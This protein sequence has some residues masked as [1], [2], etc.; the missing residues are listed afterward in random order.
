MNNVNGIDISQH[1]GLAHL[2]CKNFKALVGRGFDY[3]DLFQAAC[4]GLIYAAESYNPELGKFSTYAVPMAKRS[5]QILVETQSRTVKIPRTAQVKAAK[6]VRP[7]PRPAPENPRPR[8]TSGGPFDWDQPGASVNGGRPVEAPRVR[9]PFE[10]IPSTWA[11][12]KDE[13]I[14]APSA[15]RSFDFT[16]GED[17][18][19]TLHDTFSDET[20]ATPEDLV[21]ERETR[22]WR[23]N[24]S[25]Q[26]ALAG[27]TVQERAILVGRLEGHTQPE[28]AATF[29]VT[30]AR[31]Q[32]IEAGASRKM[33]EA[34]TE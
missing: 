26:R 23:A 7:E 11:A 30:K 19:S 8:R 3:D 21:A 2:A 10:G 15:E 27:L 13:S 14:H 29:G 1:L 12:P 18:E 17:G 24:P 16:F 6:A 25:F 31:I 32:Q 34:L 22:D 5:V 28:L 20:G 4:E 33:A 9:A